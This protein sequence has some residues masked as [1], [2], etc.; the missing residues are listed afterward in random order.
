MVDEVP[1]VEK[2]CF[3][4]KVRGARA[5]GRDGTPLLTGAS[6]GQRSEGCQ[7]ISSGFS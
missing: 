6:D 4:I 2:E 7:T 3:F 5:P 1:R